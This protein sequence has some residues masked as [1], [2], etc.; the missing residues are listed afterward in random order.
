M[1][2][3]WPGFASIRGEPEFAKVLALMGWDVPL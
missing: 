3:Y 1:A 2:L